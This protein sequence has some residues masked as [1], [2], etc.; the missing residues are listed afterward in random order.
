QRAVLSDFENRAVK[1]KTAQRVVLCHPVKIAIRALD[2]RSYRH[3]TIAATR[4]R[5]ERCERAAWTQPE[6]RPEPMRPA[7]NGQAVK[8][9]VGRLHQPGWSVP[10]AA[11]D[12]RVKIGQH[13]VRSNPEYIAAAERAAARSCSVKISIGALN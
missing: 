7:G 13:T 5:I 6:N 10:V 8:I 3:V 1:R 4:K 11:A 12:E 9:S 2:Q